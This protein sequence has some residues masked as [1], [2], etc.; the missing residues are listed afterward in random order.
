M[1]LGISSLLRV[2]LLWN[3]VY[4]S[5]YIANTAAHSHAEVNTGKTNPSH[6]RTIRSVY[7]HP[8]QSLELQDDGNE[9][10]PQ[11]KYVL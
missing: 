5:S 6:V 10:K 7:S 8:G 9:G 4:V 3:S 11:I 1:E 2:N